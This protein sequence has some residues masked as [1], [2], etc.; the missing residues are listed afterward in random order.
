MHLRGINEQGEVNSECKNPSG[1]SRLTTALCRS[2]LA[3]KDAAADGTAQHDVMMVAFFYGA[4][5]LFEEA[6]QR[7]AHDRE[8]A[9]EEL[10]HVTRHLAG[11]CNEGAGAFR[12]DSRQC[13]YS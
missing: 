8:G 3:P 1:L 6:M 11:R 2:V 7:R 12:R 9:H 10:R 5:S 13:V 4:S